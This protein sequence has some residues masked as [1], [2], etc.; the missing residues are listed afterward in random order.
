[1]D[2]SASVN[3]APRVL[4]VDYDRE[5]YRMDNKFRGIAYLINFM[6]FITDE[7]R[8]GSLVDVERLTKVLNNLNF[9]VIEPKNVTKKTIFDTAKQSK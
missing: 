9:R 2:T 8:I 5:N 4:H 7:S 1:M 3:G 6:D